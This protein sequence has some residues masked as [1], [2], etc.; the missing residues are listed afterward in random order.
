MAHLCLKSSLDLVNFF[1]AL[2][3][4]LTGDVTIDDLS[5]ND[6]PDVDLHDHDGVEEGDRDR[7][8]GE[9]V[10]RRRV[11]TKRPKV[12]AEGSGR[13]NRFDEVSFVADQVRF[14]LDRPG[15]I[16]RRV[17]S[18]YERAVRV[19]EV[20]CFEVRTR[21]SYVDTRTGRLKD[22]VDGDPGD[23]VINDSDASLT[24]A[25]LAELDEWLENHGNGSG[26]GVDGVA[27]SVNN[28]ALVAA[29]PEVQ[30]VSFFRVNGGEFD[31]MEVCLYFFRE[32]DGIER[33]EFEGGRVEGGKVNGVM[34][35][36]MICGK[37]NLPGRSIFVSP[38]NLE[39]LSDFAAR[40]LAKILKDDL[41]NR[42]GKKEVG[43]LAH[44]R[45]TERRRQG[46]KQKG[47]VRPGAGG[48]KRRDLIY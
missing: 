35:R 17:P 27:G 47:G 32:M 23:L 3:R 21:D 2:D 39:P 7:D 37:R 12:V 20:F 19:G 18:A 42:I 4:R 9:T 6:E 45:A 48:G 13:A 15:I 36:M 34:I 24:D 14:L 31:G 16:D 5:A 10:K 22:D 43:K 8:R 46:K 38:D 28:A 44:A 29:T 25:E 26:G 11:R 30:K 40:Q 33:I 1:M 41:Q